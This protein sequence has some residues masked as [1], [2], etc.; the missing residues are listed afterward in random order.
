LNQIRTNDTASGNRFQ[1][2]GVGLAHISDV[3]LDCSRQCLRLAAECSDDHTL[4]G[5][6]VLALQLLLAAVGDAELAA[7][8]RPILIAA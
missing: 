5:L 6:Q 7:D 8:E 2:R 4:A 1:T 3:A